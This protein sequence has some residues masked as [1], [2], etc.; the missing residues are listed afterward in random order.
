ME[1]AKDNLEIPMVLNPE[2]MARDCLDELSAMTYVSYFMMDPSP[3]YDSILKRI[4]AMLPGYSINNFTVRSQACTL[5]PVKV[6]MFR[7]LV[8][9]LI[10]N[11]SKSVGFF[12]SRF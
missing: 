2:D 6:R 11:R 3:G 7:A 8:N 5:F 4:R 9:L 10:Q 12:Q 1:L